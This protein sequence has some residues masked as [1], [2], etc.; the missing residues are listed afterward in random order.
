MKKILTLVSKYFH[1]YFVLWDITAWILMDIETPGGSL[2][3][4]PQSGFFFYTAGFNELPSYHF[5]PFNTTFT[6]I[7]RTKSEKVRIEYENYKHL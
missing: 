7:F 6:H 3:T 1:T 2:L 5:E 4:R